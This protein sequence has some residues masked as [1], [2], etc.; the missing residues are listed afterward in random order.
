MNLLWHWSFLNSLQHLTLLASFLE[1]SLNL[2][3]LLFLSLLTCSQDSYL[4]SFHFL[5]SH[6]WGDIIH[7]HDFKVMTPNSISSP[8]PCP[9]LHG[10]VW[11]IPR[12][13]TRT[14]PTQ[15]SSS[16][17]PSHLLLLTGAR[18]NPRS[19]P[20]L[21]PI[22]RSWHPGN[23]PLSPTQSTILSPSFLNSE[24]SGLPAGFLISRPSRNPFAPTQSQSA[25]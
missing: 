10:S 3:L 18:K 2:C 6:S 8:A 7:T 9:E 23:L 15:D 21:L 4:Y 22:P 13:C 19:H 11:G 5:T 1:L 17:F 24:D 16:S 25:S 12:N 20:S 14:C